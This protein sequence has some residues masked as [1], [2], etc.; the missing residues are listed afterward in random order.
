MKFFFVN[1]TTI[2]GDKDSK[3]T[4]KLFYLEANILTF[5]QARSI[6][7]PFW[8]LYPA[9]PFDTFSYLSE[10]K[11]ESDFL[12]KSIPISPPPSIQS[13]NTAAI[14]RESNRTRYSYNPQLNCPK[15]LHKEPTKIGTTEC[16]YAISFK[17][18]RAMQTR[19]NS[20]THLWPNWTMKRYPIL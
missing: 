14:E 8:V 10:E 12:K 1:S 5:K 9:T 6:Q 19:C 16:K 7:G 11:C 17:K 15:F 20:P 13:I 18:I 4:T 2:R 3:L